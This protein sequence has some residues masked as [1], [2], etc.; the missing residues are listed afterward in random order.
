MIAGRCLDFISNV[1]HMGT[2][3]DLY[4]IPLGNHAANTVDLPKSFFIHLGKI[5]DNKTKPG[6]AI[7]DF[8]KVFMPPQGQ[9]DLVGKLAQSDGL[10]RNRRFLIIAANGRDVEMIPKDLGPSPYLARVTLSP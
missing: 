3:D 4:G 1:L 5:F 7:R 10:V 8:L 2:D 9:K 6:S